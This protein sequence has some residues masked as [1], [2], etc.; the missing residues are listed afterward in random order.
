MLT[1]ATVDNESLTIILL[2]LSIGR[3][4]AMS[5]SLFYE[6]RMPGRQVL[7]VPPLK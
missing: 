6:I 3:K 7:S 2:A 5:V 1:I 4:E